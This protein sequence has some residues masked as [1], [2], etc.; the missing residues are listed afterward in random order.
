MLLLA[1]AIHQLEGE[2]SIFVIYS[3][4]IT[5]IAALHKDL[6]CMCK[7]SV[8]HIATLRF[9]AAARQGSLLVFLWH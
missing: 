7:T 3:Q 1:I 9:L 2:Q 8:L 4:N 6:I 5:R